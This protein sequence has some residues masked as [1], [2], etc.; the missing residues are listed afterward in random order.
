M[1]NFNQADF[2]ERIQRQKDGVAS[3]EDRRLLKLYATE[4]YEETRLKDERDA[5]QAAREARRSGQ[6]PEQEPEQAESG[7]DVGAAGKITQ[8][9]ARDEWVRLAD[10][11][12]AKLAEDDRPVQDPSTATKQELM[13]KYRNW[14]EQANTEA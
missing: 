9:S 5:K 13:D 14:A 6:E 1:R 3:D 11:V 10:A 7:G 2:E 4:G 8:R 12:N